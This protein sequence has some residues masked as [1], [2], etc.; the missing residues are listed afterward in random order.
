[1]EKDGG[2]DTDHETSNW[3]GVIAE[4]LSSGT[5]SHNLG[6]GSEKLETEQ[7]EV[8]EE[9]DE[10]ESKEDVSP[11]FRGVDTAGA[12]DFLPRRIGDISFIFSCKVNISDMHGAGGAVLARLG[13]FGVHDDF[14]LNFRLKDQITYVAAIKQML[15]ELSKRFN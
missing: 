2:E 7:E 12:T 5:S 13:V 14:L 15:C 11:L 8:K 4:K 6:S 9:E 10:T 1:M 3:V